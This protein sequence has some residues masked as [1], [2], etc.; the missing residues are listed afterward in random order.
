[1]SGMAHLLTMPK[2]QGRF[3]FFTSAVSRSSL[4]EPITVLGDLGDDQ[5]LMYLEPLR[6]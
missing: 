4:I 1:M 6:P 5:T 2:N 3:H